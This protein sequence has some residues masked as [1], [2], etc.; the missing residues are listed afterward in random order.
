MHV[1][2]THGYEVH[3]DKLG[4][5]TDR[6]P[7]GG[8]LMATGPELTVPEPYRAYAQV[9]LEADSE[10]MPSHGPHDLAI[11]LTDG[12]Q[13]PWGPIYNLSA[14]EL[15]TLRSYL[16]VQLKWGWIRP[17][18]SPAGAPV[19]FVPKKDGTLQLCVDFWGLNQI[20]KKN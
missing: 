19:F 3:L 18:K 10:S 7:A 13:L 11:E 16:N 2:R 9:F 1:E 20:T 6:D 5:N 17:S 8:V 14:K 12:K 4:L 15:D